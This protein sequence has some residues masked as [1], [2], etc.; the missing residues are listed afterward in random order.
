MAFRAVLS[1]SPPLPPVTD[2]TVVQVVPFGRGLDLVRRAVRR[3]PDQPDPADRVGLAEVDLDPLRIGEQRSPTGWSADASTAA[4]A[5]KAA[6]ST[7]D[8]VAG[9]FS[10]TFVAVGGCPPPP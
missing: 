6:D 8:A 1:S 4:D 7:L 3:L 5:G 9:L 10:A 2:R